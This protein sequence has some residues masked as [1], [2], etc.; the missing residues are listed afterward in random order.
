MSPNESDLDLLAAR[1][2]GGDASAAAGLRQRLEARFGPL[3]EHQLGIGP[4]ASPLGQR[5]RAE[6][7]LLAQSGRRSPGPDERGLTVQ[8]T[9]RICAAVVGNLQARSAPT[10]LRRDT[11]VAC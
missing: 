7:R 1:V 6:M 4:D 5:V 11:A 2:R 3:V 9:R 8:I 10:Q